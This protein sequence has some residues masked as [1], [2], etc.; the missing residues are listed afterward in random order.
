MAG[1]GEAA[2]DCDDSLSWRSTGG[3]LEQLSTL[4]RSQ[5]ASENRIK[6]ML[7]RKKE[8]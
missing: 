8:K 3:P 6:E 7:E 2:S 1:G 5:I 4:W